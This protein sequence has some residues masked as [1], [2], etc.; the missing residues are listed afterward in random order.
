MLAL[1]DITN[2]IAIIIIR[3]ALD[4]KAIKEALNKLLV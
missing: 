3:K 4:D 2:N 1:R